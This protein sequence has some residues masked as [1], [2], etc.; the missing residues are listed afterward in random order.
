MKVTLV[1]KVKKKKALTPEQLDLKRQ[2]YKRWYESHKEE[3]NQRRMERYYT[4]DLFRKKSIMHATNSQIRRKLT[5]GGRLHTINWSGETVVVYK[6]G[7]VCKF[8]GIQAPMLRH[9]ERNEKI[10]KCSFGT[11]QRCYTK[12]QINLL[13][14][15]F[16]AVQ[17]YEGLGGK[18]LTTT[19]KI[20]SAYIHKH[21]E[22]E[23]KNG[24][25]THKEK[26]TTT[27]KDKQ[28]TP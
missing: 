17:S 5:G 20:M 6:L 3:F 11:F 10:P 7:Y 9:Y 1:K 28:K 4:D 8:L 22:E 27:V 25:D 19:K 18:L 13:W 2:A 16:V 15:F 21:W 24:T 26:G 14:E 23:F 12:K